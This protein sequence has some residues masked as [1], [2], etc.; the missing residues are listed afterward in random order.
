MRP[1]LALVIGLFYATG[2]FGTAL[3]LTAKEIGLMLRA[4]YSDK[5]VLAEITT[6]HFAG[7]LDAAAE[8]DLV[9]SNASPALISALKSGSYAA[10]NEEVAHLRAVQ[11]ERAFLSESS[12]TQPADTG[13]SVVLPNGEVVNY[14]APTPPKNKSVGIAPMP[15]P[16]AIGSTAASS[17]KP[18]SSATHSEASNASPITPLQ[19]TEPQE[20]RQ[21]PAISSPEQ[22]ATEPITTSTPEETPQE[23]P[24]QPIEEQPEES[25]TPSS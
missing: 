16:P 20:P 24:E 4:G 8:N 9:Q 12:N 11:A 3:P 21:T 14:A 6:R 10:S 1:L 17:N 13:P 18:P 25:P 15:S 23:P 5:S 19:Q 7:T 22:P 2:A